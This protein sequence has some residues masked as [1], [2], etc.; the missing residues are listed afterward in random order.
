MDQGIPYLEFVDAGLN[1][2]GRW[3]RMT[4]INDGPVRSGP[5]TDRYDLDSIL[6]IWQE[7]SQVGIGHNLVL[8]DG[9]TGAALQAWV[10]TR[11]VIAYEYPVTSDGN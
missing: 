9:D 3:Y 11:E 10:G 4:F 2:G 6:A 1:P 8:Y 7:L 5:I